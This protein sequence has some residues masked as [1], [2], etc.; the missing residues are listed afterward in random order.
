MLL[1]LIAVGIWIFG[2]SGM[3]GVGVELLE[4]L[5]V[6]LEELESISSDPG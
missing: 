1:G 3:I 4:T 6:I 2:V 5:I